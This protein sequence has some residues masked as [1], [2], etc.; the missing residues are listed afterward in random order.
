MELLETHKSLP[1]PQ[2]ASLMS[3]NTLLYV[4]GIV[5]MLCH[6]I[7]LRGYL[8]YNRPY[9]SSN[10]LKPYEAS[11]DS[12]L[13]YI[14]F[15][16]L[17]LISSLCT[18]LMFGKFMGSTTRGLSTTSSPQNDSFFCVWCALAARISS[19][20]IIQVII[21]TNEPTYVN[22]ALSMIS[23]SRTLK[24]NHPSTGTVNFACAFAFVR[25]VRL[26]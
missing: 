4:D 13:N 10:S 14:A 22:V 19:P 17:L 25:L 18:R 12:S 23:N 24:L 9:R 16:D 6:C 15:S 21:D 5:I 8:L 26:R 1:P 11:T 2:R 3:S 7:F 20:D